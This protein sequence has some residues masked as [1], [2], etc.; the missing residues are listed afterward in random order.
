[1][2]FGGA[3]APVTAVIVIVAA[4]ASYPVKLYR[5]CTD[6]GIHHLPTEIVWPVHILSS[7]NS[8]DS[9]PCR[10][11]DSCNSD[12]YY[13][14]FTLTS[15]DRVA[16]RGAAVHCDQPTPQPQFTFLVSSSDKPLLRATRRDHPVSFIAISEYLR[17]SVAG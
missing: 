10:Q 3:S 6:Q 11:R 15:I 7:K 17:P 9:E 1:M 14:T 5:E 13:F 16:R 4:T 12:C 8:P 2:L